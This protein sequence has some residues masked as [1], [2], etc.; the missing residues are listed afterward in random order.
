MDAEWSC[1][2]H[3]EWWRGREVVVTFHGAVR[4]AAMLFGVLVGG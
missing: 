1:R 3:S 4:L 2:R